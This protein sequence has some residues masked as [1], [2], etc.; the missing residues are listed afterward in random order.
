MCLGNVSIYSYIISRN[1]GNK[2]IE[3]LFAFFKIYPKCECAYLDNYFENISVKF[4]NIK[5]NLD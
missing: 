1:P 4:L 3:N 5:I 2:Y